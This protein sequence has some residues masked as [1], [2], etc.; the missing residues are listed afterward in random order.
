MIPVIY[1]HF[2]SLNVFIYISVLLH[3]P[4]EVRP[5]VRPPRGS[6]RPHAAVS[7]ARAQVHTWW[8]RLFLRP[9]QL[10]RPHRYVFVLHARSH[11]TCIPGIVIA[12]KRLKNVVL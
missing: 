5:R 7:L 12:L 4:E 8:P 10:L 6:S 2:N 3:C 1:R 11:G 9:T